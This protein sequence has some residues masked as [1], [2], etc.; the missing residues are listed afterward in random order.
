MDDRLFGHREPRWLADLLD[1]DDNQL[2]PLD[3]EVGGSVTIDAT[4]RLG[5]SASLDLVDIGQ[6]VDWMQ[7]RVRLSY[8]PGVN[9]VAPWSVAV[10]LF[11][12]PT[13]HYASDVRSYSGEMLPKL[14][15]LD[16]DTVEETYSLAEGT[17]I[18]PAVIALI[19]S[20]GE[21]RILSVASDVQ[22]KSALVFEAGTPKLTVINALLEAAGYWGLWCDGDGRFRVEPY[23]DPKSRTP[24]VS[25]I[26]GATSIHEPDWT[27]ELDL[28]A[29]PNKFVVRSSGS[30][31]EEAIVG[32]AKNDDPASPFSFQARGGRWI[33]ETEEGVEV[34]DVA[35]ANALAKRRLDA[36][37]SPV[38]KLAVSHAPVPI[39]P[40]DVVQFVDSGHSVNAT[41][42]G[43]TLDLTPETLCRADWRE[44]R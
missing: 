39:Q 44:I 25:F 28:S 23:S 24:V 29:V 40:R 4:S 11:T 6:D 19:Q 14:A 20:A 18:I 26:Q 13:T 10:L 37:M 41:V 42:Q 21:T 8:D 22:L 9:G 34:E 12:S 2:R 15:I 16:E 5:G 1:A 32:V 30:D 38:A 31:E 33:T 35:A 3:G 17:A 36:R 43:M 27:R 7:H